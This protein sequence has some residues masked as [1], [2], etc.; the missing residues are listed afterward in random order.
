MDYYIWSTERNSLYCTLDRVPDGNQ[1]MFR[2]R[3]GRPMG[4]DYPEPLPFPMSP[5]LGGIKVAELVRN[6]L[7]YYIVGPAVHAVLANE[8]GAS[9]EFL[10]IDI[11]NRKGRREEATRW[12]ANLLGDPVVCADLS[13]SVMREM[14][15]K[16]GRYS[17]LQRLVLDARRIDP[18]LKIFRLG[19]MPHL[20]IVRDDLRA[21]LAASGATAMQF[22]AMG[23]PVMFD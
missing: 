3:L 21:A 20:F 16:K 13:K 22:H 8:S 23:D 19:E 10:P 17:S 11:I 12:I 7:G 18:S 15:L 4:A 2:A 14:P 5:D 1:A 9:F 6:T